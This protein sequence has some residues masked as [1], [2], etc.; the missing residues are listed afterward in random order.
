LEELVYSIPQT[1]SKLNLSPWTIRAW[2]RSGK[3]AAVKLGRRVMIEPSE[4][5]RLIS[6]GRQPALTT[7]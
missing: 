4:I 6:S 1:A 2:I 5:D 3:I 7:A